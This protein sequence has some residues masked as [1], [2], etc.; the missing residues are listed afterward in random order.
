[1]HGAQAHNLD[2]FVNPQRPPVAISADGGT[3]LEPSGSTFRAGSTAEMA[4]LQRDVQTGPATAPTLANTAAVPP[5]APQ[6][7]RDA[8]LARDVQAAPAM[9]GLDT[10]R[11]AERRGQLQTPAGDAELVRM[12]N[13]QAGAQLPSTQALLRAGIP[14][15]QFAAA[16]EASLMRDVRASTNAPQ[17]LQQARALISQAWDHNQGPLSG[18]DMMSLQTN[19][20]NAARERDPASFPAALR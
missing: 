14:E 12:P 1:M 6:T 4:R 3:R 20:F 17:A 9:T 8:A 10:L 16:L 19:V 7:E 5:T 13:V 18:A 15:R 2:R 11:A